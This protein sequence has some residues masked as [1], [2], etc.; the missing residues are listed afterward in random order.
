ML[1]K[2]MPKLNNTLSFFKNEKN[3]R[4]LK[5]NNLYS[6]CSNEFNEKISLYKKTMIGLQKRLLLSKIQSKIYFQFNKDQFLPFHIEL[7]ANV[8]NVNCKYI[9]NDTHNIFIDFNKLFSLSYGNNINNIRESNFYNLSALMLPINKNTFK[10]NIPLLKD[11]IN[12]GLLFNKTLFFYV[13]YFYKN[14]YYS[15][16]MKHNKIHIN[17]YKMFKDTL[18]I[19]LYENKLILG[20]QKYHTIENNKLYFMPIVLCKSFFKYCFGIILHF[21]IKNF[22]VLLIFYIDGEENNYLKYNIQINQVQKYKNLLEYENK[23]LFNL[24]KPIRKSLYNY[25]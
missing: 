5:E 25:L 4:F 20:L 2:H 23:N 14:N 3:T 11:K 12:F 9:Y 19:M 1:A 17:L 24:S 16:A 7:S 21:I 8:K 22:R 10:L 15:I 6:L 13:N 18:L